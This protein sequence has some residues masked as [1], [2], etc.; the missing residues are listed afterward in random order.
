MN[1]SLWRSLQPHV[2]AIA[3]FLVISC[4]YCLPALK[5]MSLNQY[6]QVN[7]Q[8]MSHQSYEF[9]EK[10]GHVPLWT[11]SLFS[12][13][14][15]YQIALESKHNI[16]IAWL[17][18]VFTLFLP[19]P[20]GLFFLACLG[21]YL[22]CMVLGVRSWVAILGS[23]A[24]AF[25][26]YDAVIVAVGHIT[27]FASMGYTPA[28]LAG[29]V[30]LTQRKYVAGFITILVFTTTLTFQGHFQILYYTLLIAV[31][32]GIAFAIKALREKATK[33]L[34]ITASLAFVAIAMG[35]A[36]FAV[37]LLPTQDYSKE[38]MRGG[39]SELTLGKSKENTGNGSGL[40][41]DYAFIYSYGVTE[42]FSFIAPR[43]FGGSDPE[44][45]Q[46]QYRSELGEQSRTAAALSELTGMPE[47][48]ASQIAQSPQFSPYW[49]QQS[50][51]SGATY[52]GAVICFL[53]ILALVVYRQWHLG[54][55]IAATLLGFMLAWGKY[56]PWFNNF[57]FDYLPAYN[58][59]RAPSM[60]LVIPQLTIP[61]LAVLGLEQVLNKDADRSWVWKRLKITA[62]ITG[63]LLL[64]LS[65]MYF[66]F[67]YT[68][69]NDST[70]KKNLTDGML[71]QLSQGAKPTVEM[72][73]RANEF[74]RVVTQALQNDRKSLFGGDLLRSL[75]FIVLAAG[76]LALYAKQK[77]TAQMAAIML[78]IL[79]FVDLMGVDLRYLRHS[80]Y[81][82]KEEPA[83][84]V[85][86]A[87]DQQIKQD[88]GYY[89]VLNVMNGGNLLTDSRTSYYHNN[90]GGYHAARL[91][92]YEDLLNYQLSQ[93]NQEAFNML[94]T[95][96][97]IA[98]DPTTQQPVVERNPNALGACWLVKD[99]KY[100]NNA[101]EEMTALSNFHPADTVIIDK[102]EQSKIAFI[103]QYDSLASISLIQNLND[104]I[105]YKFVA[106]TNQFAVF[107]EV[108]YPRGWKAFIDGKETPI[109]KVN[110]ALRG[111]AIPAGSHTIT[112]NFA[113]QSF[114]TGDR[115]TLIIGILSI[116]IIL[117][118]LG[119]GWKKYRVSMQ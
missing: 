76:L 101:N 104:N 17:H 73:Q 77:L 105:S 89:R 59:L 75:L 23:L 86:T 56:F 19:E 32:V 74:G 46:G 34:L 16:H 2:I 91:A 43:I 6:D 50:S 53:F 72:E 10:H 93:N 115:I 40:E 28:V 107:S 62:L 78:T 102:R 92:L 38:S 66:S 57:V 96:Y 113:P 54:W 33:H 4:I 94:N 100:V 35:I 11:N 90:V 7:W 95:K 1:N 108:Y 64:G 48:E 116:L 83:E 71:Q 45:I 41:R 88:T 24:Y 14:P 119:Y 117:A 84:F 37:V 79:S 81:T 111:M 13:M 44:S 26:S 12:G 85:M 58:K 97:I 27:K 52:A 36:S 67:D 21:C 42:S 55:L 60:A 49:G 87:A 118:G 20:V 3:I 110:Y 39:R 65:I 63:A 25:A 18:G 114:I 82:P 29:L 80:N 31:L 68:G 47:D 103:P 8:G 5:G 112:F 15:T 98:P 99:I 61:V 109:V 70:R 9:K 30:L 106:P 69:A 51:T 22:L